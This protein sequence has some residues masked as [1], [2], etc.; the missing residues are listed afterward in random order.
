[1]V[2]L[3]DDLDGPRDGVTYEPAFDFNRLNRQAWKVF[4]IKGLHTEFQGELG[5]GRLV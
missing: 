4:Y 3:F 2:N 1:M 5:V